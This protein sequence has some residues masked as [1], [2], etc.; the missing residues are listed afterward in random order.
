MRNRL[1]AG[2]CMEETFDDLFHSR[3]AF[4]QVMTKFI[5]RGLAE[6]VGEEPFCGL[7]RKRKFFAAPGVVT[8]TNQLRHDAISHL[9][10]IR[11]GKPYV[12][13]P[14]DEYLSD[15]LTHFGEY[16]VRIEAD[17]GSCSY[18]FLVEKRYE[19]YVGCPDVVVWVSAGLWRTDDKDRLE[20]MRM[21]AGKVQEN[22]W[23][24]TLRDVLEHGPD[25][26]LLSPDERTL[27]LTNLLSASGA[28]KLENAGNT[29]DLAG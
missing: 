20:G 23:F 3:Q 18:D 1:N 22:S 28:D 15:G 4:W 12:M 8:K 6:V 25:A 10:V 9:V 16:L 24:V 17:T 21:R 26:E 2:V 7:G 29:V 5:K 13:R 27:R 14:Q 19:K 11:L